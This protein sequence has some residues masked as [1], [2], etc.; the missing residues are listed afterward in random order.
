M[1]YLTFKFAHTLFYDVCWFIVFWKL[2]QGQEFSY[3]YIFYS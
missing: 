3:D 1:L 2:I